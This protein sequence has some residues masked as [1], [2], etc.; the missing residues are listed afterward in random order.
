MLLAHFS[1]WLLTALTILIWSG[2]IGICLGLIHGWWKHQYMCRAR[3][4]GGHRYRF[5]R[6]R[7]RPC[8]SQGETHLFSKP[9]RRGRHRKNRWF[10]QTAGNFVQVLSRIRKWKRSRCKWCGWWTT[11]AAGTTKDGSETAKKIVA[12][13]EGTGGEVHSCRSWEKTQSL[14]WCLNATQKWLGYSCPWQAK[15]T[16]EC[17][18]K[19]GSEPTAAG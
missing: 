15:K 5:P 18:E 13:A 4:N 10:K 9:P 11:V 3:W 16:H 12:R 6:L 1:M 14:E 8:K 2:C 7:Y 19:T 17:R